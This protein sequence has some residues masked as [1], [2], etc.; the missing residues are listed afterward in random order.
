MVS[1][2]TNKHEHT[3]I[4]GYIMKKFIAAAALSLCAM[5]NVNAGN[6]F[7]D[8][9]GGPS[10]SVNTSN[11]VFEDHSFARTTFVP[12]VWKDGKYAHLSLNT[13]GLRGT[14]MRTKQWFSP[15]ANGR[16]VAR[17]RINIA[18]NTKGIVHGFFFFDEYDFRNGVSQRS[19]ELDFE[20]LT[21]ELGSSNNDK[22]LYST[23]NHWDRTN[24]TYNTESN[25]GHHDGAFVDSGKQT[26]NQWHIYKMVWKCGSVEFFID[27]EYQHGF[28]GAKV[29]CGAQQLFLNSWVPDSAWPA[30]YNSS[31]Q[32]TRNDSYKTMLVDWVQVYD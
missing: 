32:S 28:Y 2:N 11:W 16:I 20:W 5:G 3:I 12:Y 7:V 30:A 17:A 8:G 21:N 25:G 6:L 18:H 26:N 14:S 22:M 4:K 24:P 19:H 13:K 1:L 27:N 31:L 29:P 15:G 10:G 23:W 9:F